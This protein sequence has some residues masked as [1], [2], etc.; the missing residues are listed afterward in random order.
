[1]DTFVHPAGFCQNVLATG[2]CRVLGEG[3]VAGREAVVLECDHP[4]TTLL[5]GDRPDYRLQVAFD[6]V[7]GLITRLLESMAGVTTRRAE[8]VAYDTN[9]TFPEGTFSLAVPEGTRILY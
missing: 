2:R 3:Q 1:V 7:D 6:R 5:P 8:V 4:R 9:L